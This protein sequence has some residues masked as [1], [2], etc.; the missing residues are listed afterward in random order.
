MEAGIYSSIKGTLEIFLTST[1]NKD[2]ML[3][4]GTQLGLFQ[5]C[6]ALQVVIENEHEDAPEIV[7]PV[8]SVQGDLELGRKFRNH[9]NSTSRPDLEQELINLL[10]KHKAVVA[11]PGGRFRQNRPAETSDQAKTRHTT[12]LYPIIQISSLKARHS[13]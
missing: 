10:L 6:Q 9:L 13:R 11:L 2:I 8:C 5:I 12:Y 1:V 3:K 7:E 4:K